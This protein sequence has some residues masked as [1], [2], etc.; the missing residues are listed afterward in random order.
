MVILPPVAGAPV[1]KTVMAKKKPAF[2]HA[3]LMGDLIASEATASVRRLHNSFNK[4]IEEENESMTR[5]LASP[6][7]ITL[8]DE[9]QGLFTNM[10]SALAAM[11]HL[12]LKLLTKKVECR[13]VLGLVKVETELNK[14]RAWNMMGPGLAPAREKLEEKRQPSAYRFS[15][16]GDATTERLMDAIGLSITHIENGWTDRQMDLASAVYVDRAPN[17]QIPKKLKVVDRVYY[18]IK[19]A[20]KL[21]YYENQWLAL[22]NSVSDIDDIWL[23][24]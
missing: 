16:P 23:P 18:K 7:T 11:R 19:S 6:L 2:T 4:V 15:I 5:E 1:N 3:V 24:K 8:G 14:T 20:A 17:S 12:R 13:F 9:F 10:Q 22:R 21:D